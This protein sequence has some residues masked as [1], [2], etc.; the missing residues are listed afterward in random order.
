[1][2]F[3][4]F[5]DIKIEVSHSKVLS[6]AFSHHRQNPNG[7]TKAPFT[8]ERNETE[9]NDME[10]VQKTKEFLQVFTRERLEAFRSENW[11]ALKSES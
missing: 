5:V 2:W 7:Y 11:T 8:R 10:L 9:R 3:G 6:S 1:M 4:E